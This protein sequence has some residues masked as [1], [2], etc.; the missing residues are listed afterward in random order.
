MNVI[1]HYR[2]LRKYAENV[3]LHSH[4]CLIYDSREE[5]LIALA[6]YLKR[7]AELGE[8]C[9]YI[10][11]DATAEFVQ[12]VFRKMG[13]SEDEPESKGHFVL[14]RTED[15][16]GGKLD[17]EHVTESVRSA[18]SLAQEEGYS[19]LRGAAE[20]SWLLSTHFT[21]IDLIRYESKINGMFDE[22]PVTAICQYNAARFSDAVLEG[23]IKTHPVV[24]MGGEVYEN[25]EYTAPDVFLSSM[26]EA[27]CQQLSR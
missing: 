7:G 4:A 6:S 23:I 26:S 18:M 10:A 25:P 13:V 2:T 16:Y 5:Q 11:D 3:P 9:I 21:A 1:D 14:T 19:G 8:K 20:M 27:V 22:L 12:H 15:F 17:C 24:I